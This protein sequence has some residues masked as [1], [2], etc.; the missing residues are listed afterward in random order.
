MK[1]L[2]SVKP[3]KSVAVD[4]LIR[5]IVEEELEAVDESEKVDDPNSGAGVSQ[6]DDSMSTSAEPPP[7]I[8]DFIPVNFKT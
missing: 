1:R 3:G 2:S 6:D 8:G 4:Q 7:I 5:N